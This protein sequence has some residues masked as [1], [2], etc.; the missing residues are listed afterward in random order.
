MKKT[1]LVLVA[2][3]EHLTIGCSGEFFALYNEHAFDCSDAPYKRVALQDIHV[4][5]IHSLVEVLLP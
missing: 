3:E 5:D 1:H 2:H 4:A